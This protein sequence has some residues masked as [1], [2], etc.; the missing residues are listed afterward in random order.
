MINP[1]EKN[2]I[3]TS[4]NSSIPVSWW[5]L[6]WLV[7]DRQAP[8]PLTQAAVRSILNLLCVKK[9]GFPVSAVRISTPILTGSPD[10]KYPLHR[11][12]PPAQSCSPP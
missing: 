11:R 3:V 7:P 6:F 12:R 1:E 5:V 4:G 2:C 8:L 10:K 9:M